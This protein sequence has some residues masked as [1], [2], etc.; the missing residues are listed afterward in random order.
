MK[1]TNNSIEVS[2][3]R[4]ILAGG[5][6]GIAFVIAMVLT[7]RISGFGIN[8]DGILMDPTLQSPKL[9]AVWSK[10]EPL[11]LVI[12]HPEIISV[13]LLLI[14]IIHAFLY[15]WIR[16]AWPSGIKARGSRFS[17]LLFLMIFVFWEFF[18]PF[19]QLGEPV[20]LIAL[21]LSFWAL[22]ALSEGFAIAWIME[23]S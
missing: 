19:N 9:I 3:G 16:S 13:G 21:E 18:T 17:T 10:L 6:G 2:I 15:R 11:P 4:T 22:I 7:F 23:R 1:T 5:L 20:M 14:G 8:G 12:T